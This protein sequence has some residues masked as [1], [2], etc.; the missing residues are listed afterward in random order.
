MSGQKLSLTQKLAGVID[1]LIKTNYVKE[2]DLNIFNKVQYANL[3]IEPTIKKTIP[4]IEGDIRES[5]CVI[6]SQII[7]IIGAIRNIKVENISLSELNTDIKAENLSII[8]TG[9]L[10]RIPVKIDIK[11]K[12]FFDTY[13]ISSKLSYKTNVKHLGI[14]TFEPKI[15]KIKNFNYPRIIDNY[16]LIK[17]CPTLKSSVQF[18]FLT[19]KEQLTYWR[20]AVTQTKRDPKNLE[21]I[22]VYYQVPYYNIEQFKID[23]NLR[24]L[25]YCLKENS[26]VKKIKVCDIIVFRDNIK[27]KGIIIED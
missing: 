8:H 17:K 7:E 9:H 23:F 1:R 18:N 19:E 21:L 6:N 2:F 26:V 13:N 3:T 24:K 11:I 25:S 22:G 14:N 4:N 20:K 27:K 12:D 16:Y 15:N 5:S 10:K